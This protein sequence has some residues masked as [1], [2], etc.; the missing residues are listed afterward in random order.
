MSKL[1]ELYKLKEETIQENNKRLADVY[2]K[3]ALEHYY[4]EN[5]ANRYA[6]ALKYGTL[7]HKL[8]PDNDRLFR[9]GEYYKAACFRSYKDPKYKL[10]DHLK[11]LAEEGLLEGA[12]ILDIGPEKGQWGKFFKSICNPGRL[13][14][15]EIFAPYIE[16]NH[17]NDIYDNV[18]NENVVKWQPDE[19]IHYDICIMGDVLEHLNVGQAH[20]VLNKLDKI[21]TLTF[22]IVPYHY[23]Q[24]EF[25]GSPYQ[26]HVQDDLDVD[27]MKERYQQLEL[28]WGNDFK[29]CYKLVDPESTY[30]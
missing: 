28:E 30:K 22:V 10:E 11:K 1:D 18:Y 17:L 19:G 3:I 14:A 5:E 25:E 16:Q 21:T 13:D 9:N 27:V 24:D 15:V 2:D 7:A 29:G 12:N 6:L 23:Y 8:D 20:R 26:A 4:N